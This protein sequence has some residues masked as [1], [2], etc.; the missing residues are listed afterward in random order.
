MDSLSKKDESK[1]DA[2][3]S[4]LESFGGLDLD[5]PPEIEDTEILK[6]SVQKTEKPKK[7]SEEKIVDEVKVDNSSSEPQL[8]LSNK[9]QEKLSSFAGLMESFGALLDEPPQLED[10]KVFEMKIEDVYPEENKEKIEEKK[11]V[12]TSKLHAFE[13]LF[14]E[15]AKEQE[16]ID[17]EALNLKVTDIYPEKSKVIKTQEKV[18]KPKVDVKKTSNIIEKVISNLD[19]MKGK[20]QVKEQVDQITLLR[21]EFNQFRTVIQNQIA[22]QKVS[23]AGG[24]SGSGEVR[25]EFLDDVDRDS[26]KVNNK[27]L[28]YNSTTGKFV[29][30]DPN[31]EAEVLQYSGD[32]QSYTVTVATKDSSHPYFG[33][34]SSNGYLINGLVSP[35]LNFIPRNTYRFDQSDSSNDGHPLRFYYEASKTTAYTTGVTTNGT[36]GQ[37]GAYTQI[38]PTADTPPVL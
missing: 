29:G 17:E 30:S 35:Y 38:V 36:P 25:F 5:E 27:Y 10:E 3:T 8:K 1:L 23:F 12:E 34:G 14:T 32:V 21:N 4:L 11:K 7:I 37:S 6:T 19:S 26:V 20:T 15:F 16:K 28:K 2:F 13:K 24:G 18:E 31:A 33:T 9:D 22:N